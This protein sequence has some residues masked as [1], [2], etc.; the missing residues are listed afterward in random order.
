MASIVEKFLPP[1]TAQL[2]FQQDQLDD[3]PG[4]MSPY[5]PAMGV[6]DTLYYDEN[7]QPYDPSKAPIPEGPPSIQRGPMNPA[8]VFDIVSP[9]SAIV[10]G[11]GL[12]GVHMAYELA[13]KG[14]RVDVFEAQSTAACGNTPFMNPVVGS[15]FVPPQVWDC[16]SPMRTLGNALKLV[17]FC[18]DP[19]LR[20]GSDFSNF[21]AHQSIMAD[22]T[23]A[24]RTVRRDGGGGHWAGATAA[25]RRAAVVAKGT[26]LSEE[27]AA[28]V[29]RMLIE[30][31][32]L[33]SAVV[34]PLSYP[35]TKTTAAVIPTSAASPSAGG[36]SVWSRLSFGLFDSKAKAPSAAPTSLMSSVVV[37]P[38]EGQP[39]TEG[40]SSAPITIR[41]L[42]WTQA[43]AR[44][45]SEEYGVNFH[46][47]S[48]VTSVS[49]ESKGATRFLNGVY[50]LPKAAAARN[51]GGSMQETAIRT[52]RAD[53]YVFAA[54]VTN[55]MVANYLTGFVPMVVTE[56]TASIFELERSA[57]SPA[58]A[59][60]P[61][62]AALRATV[63]QQKSDGFYF[64]PSESPIRFALS[65]IPFS[66]KHSAKSGM[67]VGR[68]HLC[69]SAL[70][71]TQKGGPN[72]VFANVLDSL[73]A[74][75]SASASAA[76]FP[77]LSDA[78][79]SYRSSRR[80]A[81]AARDFHSYT[82]Y[83]TVTADGLPIAS[84]VGSYF[85]TFMIGGFGDNSPALAP[86]AAAALAHRIANPRD[87]TAVDPLPMIRFAP[88]HRGMS[89]DAEHK[90]LEER[91]KDS[92]GLGP[93]QRAERFVNRNITTPVSAVFKSLLVKVIASPY[94]PSAI[95]YALFMK[96]MTA[97]EE[98]RLTGVM[99]TN[100][101]TMHVPQITS[102]TEILPSSTPKE[103]D[104]REG[105]VRSRQF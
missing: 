24:F 35:S 94:T 31:P 9:P 40:D 50:V 19:W 74:R 4:K 63:A 95:S 52:H 17:P 44:L 16:F 82:Y 67:V 2:I 105:A 79:A 43:L 69:A 73:F 14:F 15:P 37:E 71:F 99:P 30:H 10:I 78:A 96:H 42:R 22:F 36:R 23:S 83:K 72:D 6:R 47:D 98:A 38:A 62:V 59:P 57:D 45:C 68:Q 32:S 21:A 87:E 104:F 26:Q 46:F 1:V 66:R 90:A 76:L 25:E 91:L 85:N 41:P 54:G 89:A 11:S 39:A 51:G 92:A 80:T 60:S 70:P 100:I 48:E 88:T 3:S 101:V 81:E 75:V 33:R 18:G 103:F 97:E 58:A 53:L 27:T 65:E 49:T 61:L 86:A 29:R 93:M 13:R 77:S 34:T 84:R 56:G 20:V 8:M 102:D 5:K 28:T 55:P 12:P 7:M 64:F